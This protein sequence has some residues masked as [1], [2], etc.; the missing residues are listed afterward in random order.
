[1]SLFFRGLGGFSGLLAGLAVVTVISAVSQQTEPADS[2]NASA[3]AA[4]L[5]AVTFTKEQAISPAKYTVEIDVA[6]HVRYTSWDTK[7][8]EDPYTTEFRSTG[9]TAHKIFELSHNT[10]Y[11]QGSF[12][13]TG[14]RVADMGKKTLAYSDGAKHTET[15]YNWSEN[16]AI[17]TL[18]SMFEGISTVLESG[19]RIEMKRRF[20]PLGLDAELKTVEDAK[21]RGEILEL[22]AIAPVLQKVADDPQVM[23][24]ARERARRLLAQSKITQPG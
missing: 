21:N 23:N 12:D 20:D 22:H 14:H 13:Y 7:D 19:Q 18:T 15:K 8:A 24:I 16:T 11:F 5:P 2:G 17:Q 9:E 6:G 1:M 3:S 4:N 10:N